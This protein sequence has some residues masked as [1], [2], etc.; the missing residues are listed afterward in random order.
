MNNFINV[1]VQAHNHTKT[2]NSIKHNLRVIKSLNQN[3]D[4]KNSNY[5]LAD[6]KLM[7]INNKNKKEIYNQL[8]TNYQNERAIHNEIYKKHNK[9]NLRDVK[10]T[11]AEGVFTFSEQMKEDIKNKKYT[12]NDLFK[13]AN[14][15]L[16][17]IA[18][19]YDTKINYMVLHLEESTPHFHWSIS[20]FDDKGMSL[21]HS[22]KNI[23]FLSNLQNI[24][25]KHFSKLGLERGLKKEITGVNNK[26]IQKYW[27]DKN[28]QVKQQNIILNN[29]QK[30]LISKN[31]NLL[32]LINNK[33][34]H[35]ND[36][37]V[38]TNTL[39]N[40][41][42]SL[43]NEI[44]DNKSKIKDLKIERELVSKDTTKSKEEKKVLY[45]EITQ[46]QKELRELNDNIENVIKSKKEVARDLNND[47][48]QIVKSSVTFNKFVNVQTLQKEIKRT[49]M[50]YMKINTQLNELKEKEEK[51]KSLENIVEHKNQSITKLETKLDNMYEIDKESS[52]LIKEYKQREKEDKR[53]TNSEVANVTMKYENEVKTLKSENK[54]LIQEKENQKSLINDYENFISDND[55][56]EDF[57]NRNHKKQNRHR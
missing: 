52:Q 5:I 2:Y 6:N 8:S 15:C 37:E 22:N 36:L 40:E 49:L 57:N 12:Y 51:I 11:W 27:R 44:D 21:F 16:K 39:N 50:K 41:I 54:I 26:S 53:F 25:F 43:N 23:E 4:S 34:N 55:L 35:L 14:E 7:E 42:L 17:E 29:Q 28:I 13:V 47:I 38:L 10:S 46:K 33:Q 56:S 48:N 9:R 18:A 20:N 32:N 31:E 3:I 1:R 30:E 19:V 24:G 45:S